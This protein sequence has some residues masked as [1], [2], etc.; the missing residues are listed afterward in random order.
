MTH[1]L[2][3]FIGYR[4]SPPVLCAI[5]TKD[6]G[7]FRFLPLPRESRLCARVFHRTALL[8]VVKI[9]KRAFEFGN[10]LLNEVEV[11]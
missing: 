8:K 10:A 4:M 11:D 3:L 7:Q 2:L 6:I 9:V 1:N 5:D